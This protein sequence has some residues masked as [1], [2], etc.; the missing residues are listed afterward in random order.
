MES[1]ADV[2]SHASR[3]VSVAAWILAAFALACDAAYVAVI[4]QEG[5]ISFIWPVVVFVAA[6]VAGLAASAVAGR[7]VSDP[8]RRSALLSWAAAGSI[9]TGLAGAASLV[10]VPLLPAGAV[11]LVLTSRSD[12]ERVSPGWA[13]LAVAVL[14]AGLVAANALESQ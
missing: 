2:R 10:F 1:T 7:V 11:L 14:I 9:A 5:N 4:V 6:Y 3:T 13:A 12:R 8:T